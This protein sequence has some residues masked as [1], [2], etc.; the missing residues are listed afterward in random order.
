MRYRYDI[1]RYLTEV[2]VIRNSQLNPQ[3]LPTGTSTTTSTSRL[4]M[5]PKT[6]LPIRNRRPLK[7]APSALFSVI[8]YKPKKLKNSQKNAAEV[9]RAEAVRRP[10][11]PRS[12]PRPAPR[13]DVAALRLRVE[14]RR[15]SSPRAGQEASAVRSVVVVVD[16]ANERVAAAPPPPPARCA[17]DAPH[18]SSRREDGAV[19]GREWREG[20]RASA[21]ERGRESVVVPSCRLRCRP[22]P[23]TCPCRARSGCPS[24][25]C[26]LPCPWSS[27]E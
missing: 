16:R 10:R 17:H 26:R 25:A 13:S 3:F 15:R 27:R 19:V 11:A 14:R 6:E 5:T 20:T 21:G 2:R 18:G 23:A 9:A 8:F 24:S 4:A 1:R 22:R 7:R 12:A